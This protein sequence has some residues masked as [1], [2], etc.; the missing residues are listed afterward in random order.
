MVTKF[1]VHRRKE[2]NLLLYSILLL[3]ILQA[4][5]ANEAYYTTERHVL[6][7]P[8]HVS[9]NKSLRDASVAAEKKLSDFGVE[10]RLGIF[11][12]RKSNHFSL[13]T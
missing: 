8:Q 13:Q 12:S 9:P 5:S 4:L 10:M 1:S 6:T 7:F 3:L 11:F 2:K